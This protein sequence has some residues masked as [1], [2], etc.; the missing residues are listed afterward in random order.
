MHR[1]SDPLPKT[2]TSAHLQKYVSK[3]SVEAFQIHLIYHIIPPRQLSHQGW[4]MIRF[5]I[6]DIY[7]F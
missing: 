1:L 5:E 7:E 6:V 3:H 2:V 4:S